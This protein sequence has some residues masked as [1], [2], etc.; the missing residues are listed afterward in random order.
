VSDGVDIMEWFGI[1]LLVIIWVTAIISATTGI[2]W[3]PNM[4][5]RRDENPARFWKAYLIV[6]FFS[7]VVSVLIVLTSPIGFRL[8]D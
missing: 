5:I 3:N 1:V 7:V 6:F 4:Y 8:L 2:I